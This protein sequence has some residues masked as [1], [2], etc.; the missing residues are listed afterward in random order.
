[1]AENELPEAQNDGFMKMIVKLLNHRL[2]QGDVYDKFKG[3]REV[4]F[5]LEYKVQQQAPKAYKELADLC[6]FKGF[7]N[8]KPIWGLNNPEC[9][10]NAYFI[11]RAIRGY[12]HST[13]EKSKAAGRLF[14]NV[15]K[16]VTINSEKRVSM[17][18]KSFFKENANFDK[19]KISFLDGIGTFL[20]DKDKVLGI[21]WVLAYRKS[22]NSGVYSG[23]IK[24]MANYNIG[25]TQS[26]KKDLAEQTVRQLFLILQKSRESNGGKLLEMAMPVIENAA[27]NAFYL[28]NVSYYDEAGVIGVKGKTYKLDE[29]FKKDLYKR[30]KRSKLK[31]SDNCENFLL[32]N[33]TPSQKLHK[34]INNVYHVLYQYDVKW[35]QRAAFVMK[36]KGIIDAVVCSP[37]IK[38]TFELVKDYAA[39]VIDYAA[40][41]PH[42][43]DEVSIENINN[44]LKRN[45]KYM[46]LNAV[47]GTL[48]E[49]VAEPK[50]KINKKLVGAIAEIYAKSVNTTN[51]EA[52]EF[53]PNFHNKMTKMFVDI[54]KEHDYS[55]SEVQELCNILSQGG[56]R[57]EP[58][59]K[60]GRKIMSEYTVLPKVA[61]KNKKR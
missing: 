29:K 11:R 15:L 50:R 35:K 4:N 56:G 41:R 7:E 61:R 28:D 23:F 25:T 33:E 55:R 30:L 57:E 49:P 3:V 26:D 38:P 1:M 47:S 27:D 18:D 48:F 17:G 42:K 40:V 5:L 34:R 14:W 13:T 19:A 46:E 22:D 31:I 8:N 24:E 36:Q 53:D 45:A 21:D 32:N 60:M 20:S 52:E 37:E 44:L 9:S 16:H 6:G 59:V 51:E 12:I 43:T 58:F 39:L 10:T 2:N 54:V